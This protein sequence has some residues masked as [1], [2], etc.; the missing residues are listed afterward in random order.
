[1]HSLV[2]YISWSAVRA[3][4]FLQSGVADMG[5]QEDVP[6]FLDTF[7]SYTAIISLYR[8]LCADNRR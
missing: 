8:T 5:H 1:L 4:G 2:V 7:V 3:F 6:V